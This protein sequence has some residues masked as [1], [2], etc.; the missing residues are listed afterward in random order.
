MQFS[1]SLLIIVND[2]DNWYWLFV[3][4]KNWIDQSL[5]GV[6]MIAEYYA[7]WIITPLYSYYLDEK[8][9]FYE[10]SYYLCW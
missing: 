1:V 9:V 6:L 4:Q 3:S 7:V 10:I 8:I 5:L 2:V